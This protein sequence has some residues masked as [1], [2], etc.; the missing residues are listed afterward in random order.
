VN[1]VAGSTSF[2][3]NFSTSVA[4]IGAGVAGLY[5]AYCCGLAGIDCVLVE[6]LATSGGQCLALYP[7]KRTYGI[8]GF[9][10]T[11]AKE[12]IE[13]LSM[14]CL[15]YPKKV[16]FNHKVENILKGSENAFLLETVN[17]QL[18]EKFN[19][20]SRYVILATGIGDMLPN[21]PQTISGLDK[22][23]KS[24][25]FIQHSCMR[26]DLYKNK[27]IVVVGGGDSA[28]DFAIDIAKV[29]KNVM[30]IHRRD[31]FTCETSK[32]DIVREL[33]NSGKLNLSLEHNVSELIEEGEKR[34]VVIKDKN[35]IL[36]FIE[37]DHVVFCL[38]FIVNCSS[39]LGLKKLGLK[40]ENDLVKVNVDTMKTSVD[41]FYSAG[42]VVTYPNKKK[43]IVQC[44]FEADRAIRS[45]KSEILGVV[46]CNSI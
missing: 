23:D 46:L 13:R 3:E 12:F 29:A 37:T 39:L 36:T 21:I 44:F 17:R 4:I 2:S 19:V 8:P 10:D 1:F 43:G 6:S 22:I 7:D 28:I 30:L 5:A 38:G 34:K 41:G 11:K 15:C 16:L 25:D 31:R 18:G 20:H 24:S 26:L 35:Q 33:E 45:I 27:R 40:I 42:D 14:Q 9:H 32:L